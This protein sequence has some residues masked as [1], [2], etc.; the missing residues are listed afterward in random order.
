LS[1]VTAVPR[2]GETKEENPMRRFA[3]I[4]SSMFIAGAISASAQPHLTIVDHTATEV[5]PSRPMSNAYDDSGMSGDSG[6][7][8]ATNDTHS[9]DYND[10]TI[11]AN[12]TPGQA[13]NHDFNPPPHVVEFDLGESYALTNLVVWNDNQSTW[14]AQGMRRCTIEV[15]EFGGD[16]TEIFN[17]EIPIS[18]E[19]G[20]TNMTASLDIDLTGMTGRYVRVTT[21]DSP[22]NTWFETEWLPAI[23]TDSGL[24]EV[25]IYGDP[26]GL[27]NALTQA[28]CFNDG[29]CVSMIDTDCVIAGG[30]P[31]GTNTEC[32]TTICPQPP[33]ACCMTDATCQF[34]DPNDCIAQ[35]DTPQ[36]VGTTCASANCEVPTACCLPDGSCQ[37]L[38]TND[39]VTASGIPGGMFTDCGSTVCPQ[40]EACCFSDETCSD[41][42]TTDCATA[43]GTSHGPGTSCATANCSGAVPETADNVVVIGIEDEDTR[44][45]A[46]DRAT[47][48]NPDWTPLPG[49][50]VGDGGTAEMVGA[51]DDP[52]AYYRYNSDENN[53][54]AE[55]RGF[56]G[57]TGSGWDT[58]SAV[59]IEASDERTVGGSWAGQ[60]LFAIN[61]NGVVGEGSSGDEADEGKHIFH[62]SNFTA[63]ESD[64]THWMAVTPANYGTNLHPAAMTSAW[65]TLLFTFDQAYT[66][67]EMHIYNAE[68]QGW[69]STG[70]RNCTI[71]V[72]TVNSA[73]LGDWTGVAWN[74]TDG[75][76]DMSPGTVDPYSVTEIVGLDNINAQYVL[77]QIFDNWGAAWGTG[78]AE[79]RFF[80]VEVP[81]PEVSAI[82][83][84]SMGNPTCMVFNSVS[85]TL[86]ELERA[87]KII[88]PGPAVGNPTSGNGWSTT[89][90]VSIVA[91][92][93][94]RDVGGDPDTSRH[95]IHTI[96]GRGMTGND[97]DRHINE[98]SGYEGMF[99][100]VA[101][102]GG[103]GSPP[104]AGTCQTNASHWGTY[105][106]GSEITLGD[107][108][109]WN[110]N[111]V[112]WYIQGWRFL[113]IQ[114]SSNNGSNTT[115]WTTIYDGGLPLTPGLGAEDS[116]LSLNKLAARGTL[117]V[118]GIAARYVTLINTGLG[119]DAS[120]APQFD[121]GNAALAEVRFREQ[122]AGPASPNDAI[123]E[124]TGAFVI[125]DG[126]TQYLYDPDGWDSDTYWYRVVP[127][128]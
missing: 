128:L 73:N 60:A 45:Y 39:C 117:P 79:V 30:I 33:E 114:V 98:I 108:E 19:A 41:L 57:D 14:Y 26:N 99:A 80:D 96:D 87:L 110:D 78:V 106:L 75:E 67:D 63:D 23:N 81:A 122:G 51:R 116:A 20:L 7:A 105:D 93:G 112:T 49:Y 92:S 18:H 37:N 120:W 35:G 22:S 124:G 38:L 48:L 42:L 6:S 64:D 34:I 123:F 83:T 100:T 104:N 125:G 70:I 27:G 66:L 65:L 5:H 54:F 97:G 61:G 82:Q 115:D 89:G 28:C 62:S 76:V 43:G 109:V 102:G 17:G 12:R 36:G 77:I 121:G 107:V 11:L 44:V 55:S 46:L 68:A 3:L 50:I 13:D 16:S 59:S 53:R 86:Y 118:E 1:E 71:H 10:M 91:H 32:F 119:S 29:R 90:T 52:N 95:V 101:G 25:R 15:R 9:N 72:S 111:Q 56:I 47:S 40:L 69:P 113:K 2:G 88:G 21:S 8:G 103:N 127:K 85:G 94:E 74:N 4:L 31:Q 84:V 126:G 24:S 58:T